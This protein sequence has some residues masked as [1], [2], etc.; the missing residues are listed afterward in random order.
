MSRSPLPLFDGFI[1]TP[2]EHRFQGLLHESWRERSWHVIVAEPGSGKTMGICDLRDEACRQA[3]MI[4]G[5]RYPILA[6][7]APKNDPREAALGNHLLSALGLRTRGHW[8]ERKYLLFELLSQYGVECLIIDD[9]HDLSMP[10]LI[11]L[12][13]LTDQLFLSF[14]SRPLGLCLVTAG[15][16]ASIPLKDVFDQPETMW[17]QF[18]RRLD[19]LRPYCRVASHTEGEVRAI[20][21]SLEHI[22]RP[23]FP[24]LNLQ[25]WTGSVYTW[26]THPILDPQKS[27]RVLM[28]HLMKLITTALQWSYAQ[29]EVDVSSKHLEAAA[30]QLTVRRDNIQVID[31]HHPKKE[32][33]CEKQKSPEEL[34]EPKPN[35]KKEAKRGRKKRSPEESEPP[36][37]K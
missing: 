23:S 14:P 21:L 17:M 16:G 33:E 11:F 3:G 9:A 4:G 34:E 8:G 18:R 26:L 22:Y 5:R 10:H 24:A 12:K 31:A 29:A 25:Q 1:E 30:S 36:N 2:F 7:T 19:A 35:G 13:E 6:V 28:D 15:R 37:P 32:D 20:L 27:G